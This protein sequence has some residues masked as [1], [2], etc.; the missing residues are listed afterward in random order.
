MKLGR[1]S[2]RMPSGSGHGGGPSPGAL[3]FGRPEIQRM[4]VLCAVARSLG[5]EELIQGGLGLADEPLRKHLVDLRDERTWCVKRKGRLWVP[6]QPG[7]PGVVTTEQLRR[8]AAGPLG[9]DTVPDNTLYR[10]IH[11][12]EYWHIVAPHRRIPGSDES[13]WGEGRWPTDPAEIGDRLIG[14][15]RFLSLKPT[16]E[17]RP[18]WYGVLGIGPRNYDEF[19]LG[20]TPL[21]RRGGRMGEAPWRLLDQYAEAAEEPS[22]TVGPGVRAEVRFAPPLPLI[23]YGDMVEATRREVQG[24]LRKLDPEPDFRL[25]G[26]WRREVGG[27]PFVLG[28]LIQP[29]L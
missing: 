1:H 27:R 24:W 3:G 7:K 21:G 26:R 16:G 15:S 10:L 20:R 11:F 14:P 12:L 4:L 22:L 17:D 2:N 9:I 23:P 13:Y 8:A 5:T 25:E 28:L 18:G 19:E 6:R 29:E